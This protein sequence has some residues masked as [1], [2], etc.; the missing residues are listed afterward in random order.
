MRLPWV[1]RPDHYIDPARVEGIARSRASS[2]SLI[3]C[4]AMT[5]AIESDANESTESLREEARLFARYIAGD[6]QPQ[7]VDR[8][9]VACRR[10]ALGRPEGDD[11]GLLSFV[12]RHPSSLAALDAACGI[13]RPESL[14]RRKLFLMLALLETTPAHSALFLAKPR[15]W[16]PAVGHLA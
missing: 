2:G 6:A 14:L 4:C 12:R 15:R 11:L 8:Y 9:I 7:L 3:D 13:I 10:L 16:L 5:D 1:A